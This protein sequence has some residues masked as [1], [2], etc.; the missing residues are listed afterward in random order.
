MTTRGMHR[1]VVLLA[2]AQALFQTASVMVMTVG[3]LAGALVAPRPEWATAPIASM[4]LGTALTTIPASL[5]MARVGRRT[6]FVVGAV[7]GVAG[8]LLAAAGIRLLLKPSDH[9]AGRPLP[10]AHPAEDRAANDRSQGADVA[11]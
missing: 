10:V 5:W 1:Q 3:G 8:G 7:L 4:F 9:G 6:G 2:G 11:R